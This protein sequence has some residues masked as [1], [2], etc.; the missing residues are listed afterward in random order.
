MQVMEEEP[1]KKTKTPSKIIILENIHLHNLDHS[2]VSCFISLTK[3]SWYE[4]S[5]SHDQMESH[6]IKGH[7][8]GFEENSKTS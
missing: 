6:E 7:G 2:P 8:R 5:H 4:K 1:A 3:S